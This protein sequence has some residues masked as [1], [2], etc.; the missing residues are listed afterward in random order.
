M[1]NEQQSDRD[2]L[3]AI[4]TKLE[5]VIQVKED[6]EKRLR[7]LEDESHHFVTGKQ[8]WVGLGAAFG[9]ASSVFPIIQWLG[10]HK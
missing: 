7:L 10:Q 4:D 3:V 8:L 6:H 1:A 2:L 9:A 5:V